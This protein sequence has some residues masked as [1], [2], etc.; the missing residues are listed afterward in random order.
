M[1]NRFRVGSNRPTIRL[2]LHVSIVSPHPK[3]YSDPNWQKAMLDEYN[4]LIRNNNWTFVPRQFG[5]NIFCS[6]WLFKHKYVTD[7][8]LSRYKARL[9]ANG[10]SQQLDVDETFSPVFK[11]TIIHIVL[12]LVVS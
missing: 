3:S 1:V 2:T 12:S 5:A 10:S 7:G 4:A 8:S 11:P 9:V 6:I